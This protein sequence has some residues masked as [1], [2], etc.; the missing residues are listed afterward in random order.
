MKGER[1]NHFSPCNDGSLLFPATQS[2]GNT[3]NQVSVSKDW[4]SGTT[5]DGYEA[6]YKALSTIILKDETRIT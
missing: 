3:G 6:I 4:L 2:T 1:C 5:N